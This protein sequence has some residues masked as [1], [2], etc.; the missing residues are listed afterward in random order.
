MALP[1]FLVAQGTLAAAPRELWSRL[2]PATEASASVW[3][4]R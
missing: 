4:G 3:N 2:K 1:H